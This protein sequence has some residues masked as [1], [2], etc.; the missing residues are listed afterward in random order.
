MLGFRVVLGEGVAVEEVLDSE[1]GRLG[2]LIRF[3][4]G[5]VEFL[6]RRHFGTVKM[7][8]RVLISFSSQNYTALIIAAETLLYVIGG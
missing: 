5:R 2:V 3:L 6:L 7:G 1:L 4:G 8:I